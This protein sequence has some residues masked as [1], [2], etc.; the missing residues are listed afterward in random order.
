MLRFCGADLE[1]SELET[2]L[3]MQID[4]KLNFERLIKSLCGKASPKIGASQKN[5]NLLDRQK[6]MFNSI[7]KSQISYCSLIWMLSSRRSNSLVKNVH[8]K[9][10]RIVYDDISW[11][12]LRTVMTEWTYYSCSCSY[13]CFHERNL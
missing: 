9:A 6:K 1:G 5:L 7:I 10:L 11:H 4:N 3:R 13:P 8:E 12:V 2:L